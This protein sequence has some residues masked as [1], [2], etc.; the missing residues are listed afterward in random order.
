MRFE[1]D[2]QQEME[3]IKQKFIEELSRICPEIN[4]NLD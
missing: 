2:S 3:F 1:G 4:I